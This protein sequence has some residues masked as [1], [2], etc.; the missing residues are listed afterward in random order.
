[1][2]SIFELHFGSVND[3]RTGNA[4]RHLLSDIIGLVVI[5]ILCRAEGWEEME[6][7]GTAKEPF[8]RK[9]LRLEHGI[10]SHDTLER[11]FKRL[12]PDHLE[13]CFR[14]WVAGLGLDP[15]HIS[16]DGKSLRG[17]GDAP[18]GKAM[19]HMVSAWASEA[20]ICLGQEA[21][22]RKENEHKAMLRILD[23]LDLCGCLVTMDAMGNQRDIAKKIIA[24]EGDYLTGLKENQPTILAETEALFNSM[25]PQSSHTEHDKGHSRIEKRTCHVIY[26]VDM[27]DPRHEWPGLKALVKV[28]SEITR[29]GKKTTQARYYLSSRLATASEFNSAVRSHWSIENSQHWILDVQFNED[30]C[31]KRK[32]NAAQNFAIMRRLALNILNH[33]KTPRLSTNR[34]RMKA[35]WDEN[36]L[37]K[38][39]GFLKS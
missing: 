13:E 18:A 26:T 9:V 11:V 29:N 5:A 38:L 30:L 20:G 37:I 17:S 2:D 7:F 34:K 19:V 8:L 32:D 36:Y 15:G 4:R 24:A 28:E 10:P 39:L 23:L 35:S 3:P 31:R 16:L 25:G 12:S 6:E 27:L 1:M 33:D 14:S 22:D 21:V